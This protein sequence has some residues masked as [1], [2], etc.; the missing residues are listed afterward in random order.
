MATTWGECAD[1]NC[2]APPSW[3]E[4]H[5]IQHWKRDHGKTNVEDGILLCRHHHLLY[6]NNHWEIVREGTRYWLV[7]PVDISDE[8]IELKPK[9]K[10]FVRMMKQNALKG[11]G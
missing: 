11:L 3:C 8:R 1:P 6:H 5:H 7:P 9:G 4:A 2:S 10:A